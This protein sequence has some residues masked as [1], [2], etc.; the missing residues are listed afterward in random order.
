MPFKE[1]GVVEGVAV[2]GGYLKEPI[3]VPREEHEGCFYLRV[4]QYDDWLH[5]MVCDRSKK[6]HALKQSKLWTQLLG[7]EDEKEQDDL[8]ADIMHSVAEDVGLPGKKRPRQR[9]LAKSKLPALYKTVKEIP[10]PE[11]GPQCKRVIFILLNGY[12]QKLAKTIWLRQ[13]D[14]TWFVETLHS[15]IYQKDPVVSAHGI[16]WLEGTHSWVAHWVTE[17]GDAK[18]AI[19]Y[20]VAHS[21]RG[22]VKVPM[23]EQKF[24]EKK[25]QKREELV[26]KITLQGFLG[27][28]PNLQRVIVEDSAA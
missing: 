27:E 12:H 28:C 24:Q 7:A 2:R 11:P 3:W 14:L 8:L 25:K 20:V 21:R 26:R 1:V 16:R 5:W 19:A 10:Y 18:Q 15:E 4:R 17:S 6:S 9:A 23:E 22:G 13:S